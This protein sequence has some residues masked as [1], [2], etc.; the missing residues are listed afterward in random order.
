M[1]SHNPVINQPFFGIRKLWLVILNFPIGKIIMVGNLVMEKSL[2][3]WV[4][5]WGLKK[6]QL[7]RDYVRN[8]NK[9]PGI[10]QR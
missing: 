7:Y 6:T 9:D 5:F 10:I 1:V 8:H 4:I 2:V 3:G